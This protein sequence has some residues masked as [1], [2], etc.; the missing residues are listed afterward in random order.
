MFS[1]ACRKA[2][3]ADDGSRNSTAAFRRRPVP[4]QQMPLFD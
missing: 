2:G 3:F 4:F 1:I